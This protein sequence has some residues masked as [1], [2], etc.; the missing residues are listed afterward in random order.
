MR[1]KV[2]RFDRTTWIAFVAVLAVGLAGIGL[3]VWRI[4]APGFGVESEDA[5]TAVPVGRI[6]GVVTVGGKPHAGVPVTAHSV[7]PEG[8]LDF[9]GTHRTNAD[10]RF[11]IAGLVT[12]KTYQVT[13]SAA[14]PVFAH[15]FVPISVGGAGDTAGAH[16][17]EPVEVDL[18]ADRGVD[19]VELD[20]LPGATLSGRVLS[21]WGQPEADLPVRAYLLADRGEQTG[22][23]GEAVTDEQG[24][25]TVKGL[26]P[27]RFAV[28]S[29]DAYADGIPQR[30]V[31]S[32]AAPFLPMVQQLQ[33]GAQ[34]R[35]RSELPDPVVLEPGQA[36]GLPDLELGRSTVLRGTVRDADGR[37]RR[38]VTVSLTIHAKDGVWVSGP[39]ELTDRRGRFEIPGMLPGRYRLQY[40][41]RYLGDTEDPEKSE[42]L[43]IRRRDRVVRL[44]LR[45]D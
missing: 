31:G 37:P 41:S 4:V 45:I 22:L 35:R 25:Y 7:E 6:Q 29:T 17:G 20:L 30:P 40:G 10:G 19:G 21:A 36:T 24:R 27:G 23:Y 5:P 1:G 8:E 15:D 11:V 14:L 38:D 26:P 33:A 42:L 2:G 12:G 13:V 32:G 34:D 43:R 9:A 28:S 18:P 39:S 16:F 44:D 3:V